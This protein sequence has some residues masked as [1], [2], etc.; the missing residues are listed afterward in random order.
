[1]L[2]PSLLHAVLG[3]LMLEG[4]SIA[5]NFVSWMPVV[6]YFTDSSFCHVFF[7][8]QDPTLQHYTGYKASELRDCVIGIHELQCNTKNCSLP[9]IR[10]KYRQHKVDF[11][12]YQ[13]IHEF[14]TLRL[15]PLLM[16]RP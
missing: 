5:V 15:S 1:M 16:S 9:A 2:V 6:S 3:N 8:L 11:V 14:L 4:W 12:T 7:L 10:E 13:K